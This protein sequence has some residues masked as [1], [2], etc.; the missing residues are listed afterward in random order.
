MKEIKELNPEKFNIKGM[1]EKM[2]AGYPS[3]KLVGVQAHFL[4]SF[5]GD[6]ETLAS[7]G[8]YAEG[9]NMDDYES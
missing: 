1:V 4:V 3:A 6:D 5:D 2:K 8:G 7:L 9:F